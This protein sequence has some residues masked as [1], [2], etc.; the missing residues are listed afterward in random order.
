VRARQARDRARSVSLPAGRASLPTVIPL[1]WRASKAKCILVWPQAVKAYGACRAATPSCDPCH[2]CADKPTRRQARFAHL[3]RLQFRR[4]TCGALGGPVPEIAACRQ[5]FL[6]HRARS[7][8]GGACGCRR[9]GVPPQGIIACVEGLASEVVPWRQLSLQA[10]QRAG[11]GAAG[12]SPTIAPPALGEL[13]VR[14]AAR[15]PDSYLRDVGP[16]GGPRRA[17]LIDLCHARQPAYSSPGIRWQL[18]CDVLGVW[19]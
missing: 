8:D 15:S 6:R 1:S 11:Q 19:P 17:S 10:G 16:R 14:F 7:S 4:H 2:G 13:G 12:H 5:P 3:C 9:V 18:A